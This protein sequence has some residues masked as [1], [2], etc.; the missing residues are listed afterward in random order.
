MIKIN[1]KKNGAGGKGEGGGDGE[2][3]DIVAGKMRKRS[4]LP[5]P[6]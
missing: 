2:V 5:K 4:F 6:C 3:V 1:K